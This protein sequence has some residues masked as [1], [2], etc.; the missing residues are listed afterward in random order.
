M[1]NLQQR[2]RDGERSERVEEHAVELHD[3]DSVAVEEAARERHVARE[4]EGEL[5]ALGAA[6]RH[7][8]QPS[9]DVARGVVRVGAAKAE[10]LDG[11]R[12]VEEEHGVDEFGEASETSG[13]VELRGGLVVE[14]EDRD[15]G[16][17]RTPPLGEN[18]GDDDLLGGEEG[19]D[20]EEEHI[21]E[22]AD[23]VVIAGGWFLPMR[24]WLGGFR[25][26]W[27]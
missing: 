27:W 17:E 23:S 18:A 26:R 7:V 24:R 5:H 6:A 20:L 8:T 12:V 16:P 2:Q 19:E 9:G 11:G 10:A 1:Q 13:M 15:G 25:H 21:G 3:R 14:V 4:R 22:V